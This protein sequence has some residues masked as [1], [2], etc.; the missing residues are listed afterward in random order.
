MTNSLC[1]VSREDLFG[2]N[3]KEREAR[4]NQH[5]LWIRQPRD[6]GVW[7]WVWVWVRERGA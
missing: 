4:K 5:N 2:I 7:V 3:E 6:E 1:R